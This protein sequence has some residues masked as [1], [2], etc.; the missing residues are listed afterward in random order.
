[1]RRVR[2]SIDCTRE[3]HLEAG[4]FFFASVHEAA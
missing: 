2:R 4:E 3:L 1:M